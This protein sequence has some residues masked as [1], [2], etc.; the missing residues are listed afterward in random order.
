MSRT[1][2]MERAAAAGRPLDPPL[3]DQA[4]SPG[5]GGR[6]PNPLRDRPHRRVAA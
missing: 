1:P 6:T 3:R 4:P 5:G 2:F